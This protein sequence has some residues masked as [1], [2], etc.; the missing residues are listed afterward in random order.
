MS[1]SWVERVIFIVAL[2]AAAGGFWMRFRK[3]VTRIREAKADPG[4]FH[5]SAPKRVWDFFWEVMCQAKV[6]RSVRCPARARFRVLGILHFRADHAESFRR[7]LRLPVFSTTCLAIRIYEFAALFRR[8]GRDFDLRLVRPAVFRAARVAGRVVEGIR[9]H[10][11]SD[12]RADGHLHGGICSAIAKKPLWWAHTLALLAFMPLIPH[13]K[14]LHL[15]LSPVTIFLSRGELQPIFLR[16]SA[17]TISGS[18][19]AKI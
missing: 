3:V 9:H 7:R 8:R 15:V 6:I 5:P 16:W 4:F 18:T 10:R 19:P 1:F 13:T 11:A 2:I 17:M 12:F 14:H